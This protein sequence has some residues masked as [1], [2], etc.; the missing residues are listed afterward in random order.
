ML[1]MVALALMV[2]GCLSRPALVRQNFALQGPPTVAGT[3]N[4][5]GVLAIRSFEV[6]PLFDGRP[7]VYRIGPESYEPDPYARFMVPARTALEIPVRSWLRTSGSLRDVVDPGSLQQPDRWLE[8][9]VSELYGDM[10][11]P[12]HPSA[13]L[14]MR[15]AFFRSSGGPAPAVYMQ[16]N[17]LRRIELSENTASSVVTGWDKALAEIMTEVLSDLA[18]AES[19]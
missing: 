5:G 1:P 9:R 10:R 16:K 12:A 2:A 14:V 7:L 11:D 4:A 18:A 15:F 6:S 8:V 17:Y 3:T 13:V 19:R